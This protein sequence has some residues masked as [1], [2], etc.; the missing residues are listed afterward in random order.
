MNLEHVKKVV[1]KGTYYL[2]DHAHQGTFP[3]PHEWLTQEQHDDIKALPTFAKGG[4]IGELPVDPTI[5]APEAAPADNAPAV[6]QL[7]VDPTI[8]SAPVTPGAPAPRVGQ[9]GWKPPDIGDPL[10]DIRTALDDTTAAITRNGEAKKQT[11][12]ALAAE[13]GTYQTHLQNSIDDWQTGRDAIAKQQDALEHAVL[14]GKFNPNRI[15]QDP[16]EG[17]GGGSRILATIG[18][19][20]GDVSS[21]LNGG[22]NVANQMIDGAINRD[23]EAQKLDLVKNREMLD[24]YRQKGLDLTDVLALKKANWLDLTSVHLKTEAAKLGSKEAINDAQILAA[25]KRG[26]AAQLR[27]DVAGKINAN[28]YDPLIKQSQLNAAGMQSQLQK[29]QIEGEQL[30]NQQKRYD[31]LHQQKTQQIIDNFRMRNQGTPAAPATAPGGGPPPGGLPFLLTQIGEEDPGEVLDVL[32]NGKDLRERIVRLPTGKVLYAKDKTQADK[33]QE[34][35]D[36]YSF[37]TSQNAKGTAENA[38][39]GSWLNSTAAKNTKQ[40]RNSQI[41]ELQ[42][43]NGLARL[44]EVDKELNEEQIPNYASSFTDATQAQA[45][46]YQDSL[47]EAMGAHLQALNTQG[48]RYKSDFLNQVR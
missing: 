24:Y 6:G 14:T 9:A 36:A 26:E 41:A 5:A 31:L 47:D 33:I 39:G 2:V 25:Q 28:H 32:P 29:L 13:F 11:Q 30:G 38:R 21:K 35:L 16:S 22:V 40:W 10:K 20:L 15:W 48:K 42:K 37:L 44:S 18:I 46:A 4:P 3:L 45:K 27:T 43:F 1:D 12:D 7:P 19:A 17:G 8:R 23:L 34:G